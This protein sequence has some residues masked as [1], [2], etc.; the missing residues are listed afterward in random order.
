V[1]HLLPAILLL[2]AAYGQTLDPPTINLPSGTYTNMAWTYITAAAVGGVSPQV[3][4][5]K[6]GSTPTATVAGT[7]D[8]NGKIYSGTLYGYG[9]MEF[10]DPGTFTLKVI[11]TLTG[12]TNS[13]VASATYTVVSSP[14]L[15]TLTKTTPVKV[16]SSSPGVNYYMP[17]VMKGLNGKMLLFY[18]QG[19]EAPDHGY[20]T[21]LILKTSTNEGASWQD[22][23]PDKVTRLRLTNIGSGYSGTPTCSM[24]TSSSG[25]TATCT[26]SA[27]VDGAI[28]S[29]TLD[30]A[31]TGYD[32]S[33]TPFYGHPILCNVIGGGGTGA[34]CEAW[35][36][37]TG[38]HTISGVRM[39][40]Y[41]SGYTSTPTCSIT[42]IYNTGT[43]T[44]HFGAPVNGA[45]TSLTITNRGFGYTTPPT[46]TIGGNGTGA[47]ASVTLNDCEPGD[48]ANCFWHDSHYG[49]TGGSF[50]GGV[51]YKGTVILNAAD[52][53]LG[54]NGSRGPRVF[55]SLDNGA[56]WEPSF[57][58][59]LA[60]THT[61]SPANMIS[62]QPGSPG[63]TGP[64]AAG[65]LVQW[66]TEGG[67]GN[68][69]YIMYSYDDGVTWSGM[70]AVGSL[71]P[72]NDE[73]STMAWAGGMKLIVY[74]RVGRAY[75]NNLG[76]PEPL[77]VHTSNDLGITWS[78][79]T[80]NFPSGPCTVNPDSYFW[81]DQFTKP[82]G[83]VNPKNSAQF[84]M[85]W[86]E[87]FSCP[88]GSTTR[89]RTVTFNALDTYNG[90]GQNTPMPQILDLAP[91]VV[92]G[93]GHTA[94]SGADSTAS[95]K[96]LMAWEQAVSTTAE[97]IF[98]TTLT[99]PG[100]PA[101]LSITSSSPL[102]PGSAGAPYNQALTAVGG[103]PP[104]TW[105][106]T[107]GS[108]TSCGLTLSAAGTVSG[109]SPTEATCNFTV[110]ATD[111]APSTASK[112][113]TVTI[114]A[115]V[116]PTNL[117]RATGGIKFS[118]GITLK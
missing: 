18:G 80:S 30:S 100:P 7:C 23:A 39:S 109:N 107:A 103:N 36:N 34:T 29:V 12:Y 89:W 62:I 94:Y 51:T 105:A 90:H 108:L 73:E 67:N 104:Y 58:V 9:A 49:S 13:A 8:K 50:G 78:Q 59:L 2:G 87:R 81:G 88:V 92:Y 102:P 111:I 86:G 3:C 21:M 16:T 35:A 74:T 84:T 52:I 32:V 26:A 53:E 93:S 5:T 45:V 72:Q 71:F 33:Q 43:A 64:C 65:C 79:Y 99:Y 25:A 54:W 110:Q 40:S 10:D 37:A 41:G 83:F 85:I 27:P 15:A 82:A 69:N 4:L 96:I 115:A 17:H 19:Q 60:S 118:N 66:T 57:N 114:S 22:Y 70:N 38:T 95:G 101:A 48:P 98:T 113:F 116:A 11:A 46:A 47:T 112:A 44:C 1:R 117:I 42:Q 106:V 63:V 68:S 6:D 24:S 97:D 20:A 77:Q 55:R 76:W 31:G 75:S 56:N 91:R 28:P 61:H 14:A